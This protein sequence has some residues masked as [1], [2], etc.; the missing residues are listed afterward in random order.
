MGETNTEEKVGIGIPYSK[1]SLIFHPAVLTQRLPLIVNAT[2]L[3]AFCCLGGIV[4]IAAGTK[5]E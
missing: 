4:Y 3:L 2:I 5:E 1:R